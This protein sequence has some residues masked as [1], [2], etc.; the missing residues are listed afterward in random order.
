MNSICLPGGFE[1]VIF[2]LH[3]WGDPQI[4]FIL[5]NRRECRAV[6]HGQVQ[7]GL[8]YD[9]SNACKPKHFVRKE[10]RCT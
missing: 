9:R 5:F 10:L 6:D 1:I 7:T 4:R 3:V 2:L 8:G